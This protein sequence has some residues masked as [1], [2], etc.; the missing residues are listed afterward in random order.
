MA[1]IADKVRRQ[2]YLI[3]SYQAIMTAMKLERVGYIPSYRQYQK[4]AAIKLMFDKFS[5]WRICAV[6][7]CG[8]LPITAACKIVVLMQ[9]ARCYKLG[10]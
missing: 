8:V 10:E 2:K 1:A 5:C 6:R 9:F 3:I 4:K 7:L